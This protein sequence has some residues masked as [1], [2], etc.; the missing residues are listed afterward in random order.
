MEL[1]SVVIAGAGVAG[2]SCAWWLSQQNWK[3]TVIERADDLRSSG[4]MLG[5]TGPGFS[6]IEKMGL[7][8]KL[9]C[10]QPHVQ[11]NKYH[12]AQGDLLFTLNI[13]KIWGELKMLMLPRTDL[14]KE[15]YQKVVDETD[16]EVRFAAELSD[17]WQT[18]DK[19]TVELQSGERI[20][21][22]LLIG[23][24]GVRSKTR[25]KLFDNEVQCRESLGYKVAAFAIDEKLQHET[26]FQSYVEPNRAVEFYPLPG[27]RTAGLYLWKD[28][29]TKRVD[30]REDAIAQLSAQFADSHPNV[31]RGIESVGTD[32]PLLFDDL[33][34][35]TLPNWSCGRALLLGDAAHCL[36]LLSG[37]GA[38]MAM[39][40]AYMLSQSL[41]RFDIEQALLDHERQMRPVIDRL[42]HRSR[43]L[44]PWFIP[45]SQLNFRLRNLIIKCLPN[46]II[47][48]FFLRA[49]KS[50]II[51]AQMENH[52]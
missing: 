47:G 22:D 10:Y 16:V 11:S 8:D 42:Q 30:K 29:H 34:M 50:D 46:R 33:T 39:T 32:E 3:V 27:E 31:K 19:V 2:L 49:V 35:I 17:T 25:Q 52:S 1:R 13:Q 41:A 38:G 14:V 44:A 15:L 45:S 20:S 28:A 24:D 48:W 26:N 12:N 7:L 6:A 5:L 21:A 37:Q 9:K 4:Y 43:K 23:A 18:A 36:T 40:S 51:A